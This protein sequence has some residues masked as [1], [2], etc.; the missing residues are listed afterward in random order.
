MFASQFLPFTLVALIVFGYG[1]VIGSFLNV[2]IYRFHTGKS[3]SGRSHCMSCG[4]TL[5]VLELIPLFSYLALRGRCRNCSSCITPRYFFVEVVTGLLFVA[6]A[7]V[8]ASWLEMFF[9]CVVSSILMVITVYDI[10]H[11]IIPDALTAS[12]TA[13]ALAWLVFM[14]W[15]GVDYLDAAYTIGAA[16]AASG[17]LFSLWFFSKGQWIGFGDVKLAFP[18]AIIAGAGQAFSMVVFSFWIGAGI[19]LLLIAAAKFQRGKLRLRFLPSNLTIKSVVPF[20][21][22]LVAGCLVVLF[23]ELNVLD[24]FT[25]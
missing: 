24:I 22:F 3:L 7:W 21:P 4:K 2:Y 19:S 16:A 12:L 1:A 23:T 14:V 6:S 10:R 25:F 18:L 20:A 15:S 13:L 5:K 17:F 11:Y 8:A 9:L